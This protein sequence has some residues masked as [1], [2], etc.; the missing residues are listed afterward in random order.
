M[1]RRS[2]SYLS[3]EGQQGLHAVPQLAQ[4]LLELLQ[5]AQQLRGVRHQHLQLAGPAELGQVPPDHGRLGLPHGR[6]AAALALLAFAVLEASRQRLV[7]FVVTVL[8]HAVQV[9]FLVHFVVPGL[10]HL[11][12]RRLLLFGVGKVLAN[13]QVRGVGMVVLLLVLAPLPYLARPVPVLV[14]VLVLVVFLFVREQARALHL[15]MG[16]AAPF[17]VRAGS[18]RLFLLLVLLLPTAQVGV[19]VQVKDP[20][21]FLLFALLLLP[22]VQANELLL[23]LL[24]LLLQVPL[25]LVVHHFVVLVLAGTTT[26]CC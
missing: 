23:L 25:H 2:A 22:A 7:L 19:H 9:V 21:F 15:P 16:R 10:L 20:L 8:P 12:G 5:Q 1:G 14:P 3:G 4:L 26:G 17:L 6:L 13:L 24:L 11:P 18:V